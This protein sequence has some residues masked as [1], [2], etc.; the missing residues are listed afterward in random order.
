MD[1]RDPNQQNLP[2][3]NTIKPDFQPPSRPVIRTNWAVFLLI[4]TI[5][6]Y[7]I[8][9][10]VGHKGLVYVPKEFKVVNQQDQPKVVDYNLL[11]QSIDILNNKFIDK[12][13]DPQNTLYGAIRGVVASTGD[14]YTDFFEPRDLQNFK[15]SLKG[16]FDG[17]GAEIGKKNGLITI[18]APLDGSPAQKA[19]IL[20]QDIVFQVD[21]KP[22]H[23]W[24]TEQAVDAIRGKKGTEVTLTIIREGKDKPFDVKIIRDTISIKSVKWQYKQI[25]VEGQK[26]NVAVIT[27]SQFGDDTKPLFDQAVNEILT[28]QVDGLVLDLRNDPGGYLQTAVDIASNWISEGITVVTEEHSNGT[29]QKYAASGNARLAQYKTA[30]LINGGSAS[31]A[32]IL[33]GALQDYKIS[34]LIGEKSFGKGSVQELVDLPDK[35]A[36]KVTVAKWITPGGKNLNK[37]GLEPDIVVKPTDEQISKGEDPQMNKALE[38]VTK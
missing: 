36:I 16:K 6:G 27:I 33:S 4:F 3:N 18:V 20:A 21:G 38:E 32:E 35:S 25:E 31:A 15:T 30:V 37:D 22:T 26:K 9:Y 13:L 10:K 12:P 8:G 11:W 7:L 24:S 5:I 2:Q 29:S 19:G 28:K 14:P 34:K 1:F 23:D 17:I